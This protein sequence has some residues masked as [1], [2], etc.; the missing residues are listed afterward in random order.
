[1]KSAAAN[2]RRVTIAFL[3]GAIQLK[4]DDDTTAKLYFSHLAQSFHLET[5]THLCEQKFSKKC[6]DLNMAELMIFQNGLASGSFTEPP[7]GIKQNYQ[8]CF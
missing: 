1:M 2:S 5:I 7:E 4:Y 6:S 3:A 8:A